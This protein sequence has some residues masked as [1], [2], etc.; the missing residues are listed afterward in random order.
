MATFGEI[1]SYMTFLF[2]GVFGIYVGLFSLFHLKD[3]NYMIMIG[4]IGIIIVVVS[5]MTHNHDNNHDRSKVT[6]TREE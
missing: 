1:V 3:Q 5:S 6:G 2:I 4:G